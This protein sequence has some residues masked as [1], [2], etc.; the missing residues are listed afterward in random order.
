MLKYLLKSAVFLGGV[1]YL[2]EDLVDE[3]HFGG[4]FTGMCHTFQASRDH[5]SLS[6]WLPFQSANA[7]MLRP[8]CYDRDIFPV[9]PL[10]ADSWKRLG[11]SS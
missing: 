8:L 1:C 4:I 11:R 10:S 2:L 9:F 7:W 3:R 6:P 5:E